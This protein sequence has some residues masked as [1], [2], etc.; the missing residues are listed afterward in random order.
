MGYPCAFRFIIFGYESVRIEE[1]DGV[2][3]HQYP[4]GL[5]ASVDLSG[6]RVAEIFQGRTPQG[7][8]TWSSTFYRVYFSDEL[9]RETRTGIIA[10]MLALENL[11]FF[12]I[13]LSEISDNQ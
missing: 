1:A 6:M 12:A 7:S 3:W 10:C 4:Q 11:E 5:R 13:E 2:I 8:F 9:D